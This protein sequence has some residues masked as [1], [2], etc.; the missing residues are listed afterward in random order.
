[1]L[2]N[3]YLIDIIYRHENIKESEGRLNSE[4]HAPDTLSVDFNL[5]G[6]LTRTAQNLNSG[7]FP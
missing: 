4:A 6:F 3:K 2:P 5:L 1:M 7:I